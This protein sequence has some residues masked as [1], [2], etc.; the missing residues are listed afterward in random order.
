[1][2]GR[3]QSY[4]GDP[5]PSIILF[6]TTASA[7]W[8]NLLRGVVIMKSVTTNI[9]LIAEQ[10]GADVADAVATKD[11]QLF[12]E[13]MVASLQD[14]ESYVDKLNTELLNAPKE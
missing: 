8:L 5:C 9:D 6:H 11:Y 10:I 3:R 12:Y 7:C 2:D 4:L 1:M 13:R 14:L